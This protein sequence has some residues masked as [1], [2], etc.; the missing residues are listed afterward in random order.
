MLIDYYLIISKAVKENPNSGWL[1]YDELIR[2]KASN[3]SS[4]AL[5]IAEPTLWV[6]HMLDNSK[7]LLRN[8]ESK[9]PICQLFNQNRCFYT[10]CKYKYICKFCYKSSHSSPSCKQKPEEQREKKRDYSP[11]SDLQDT[12]PKASQVTDS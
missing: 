4:L 6:T 7:G 1:N 3:D 8:P 9:K 10:D 2:E 12:P 5:G 11:K